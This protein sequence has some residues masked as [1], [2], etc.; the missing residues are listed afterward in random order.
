MTPD[1][2]YIAVRFAVVSL[3]IL[4]AWVVL[5][6]VCV[7]KDRQDRDLNQRQRDEAYRKMRD[8]YGK[9]DRN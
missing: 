8:K 4:G 3:F 2:K 9:P 7:M 1:M 6:F 5:D